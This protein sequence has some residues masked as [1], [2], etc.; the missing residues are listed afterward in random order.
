MSLTGAMGE[1]KGAHNISPL[2]SHGLWK[3][4]KK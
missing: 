4:H 2:K 1:W 3:S